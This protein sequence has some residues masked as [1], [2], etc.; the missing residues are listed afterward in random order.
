MRETSPR[1]PAAQ[2]LL[3]IGTNLARERARRAGCLFS[4]AAA[5]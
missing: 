1:N 2:V 5:V 3:P 4:S